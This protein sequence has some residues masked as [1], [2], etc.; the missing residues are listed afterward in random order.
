MTKFVEQLVGAFTHQNVLD[1]LRDALL[2]ILIDAIK[3]AID[4]AIGEI[5]SDVADL[6]E[7]VED[8]EKEKTNLQNRV[9]Q[10]EIEQR[11]SSVIIHGLPESYAAMAQ[12]TSAGDVTSDGGNLAENIPGTKKQF[13]D[14][15]VENLHVSLHDEDLVSCYRLRK[16]S[17]SSAPRPVLVKF[18]SLNAKA[19][20]MMEKK[21]LRNCIPKVYINDYLINEV[22]LL[23]SKARGYVREKRIFSTW[24]LNGRLFIKRMGQNQKPIQVSSLEGLNQHLNH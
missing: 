5:K 16:P 2:P 9:E 23:F 14:F 10:I 18:S 19:R 21:R 7:R 4:V 6:K 22:G 8:L 1:A 13:L 12:T 3:E 17:S 11:S 15:C 20:I 24:T